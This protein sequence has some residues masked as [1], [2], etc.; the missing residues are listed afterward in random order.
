MCIVWFRPC[1]RP[2]YLKKVFN[3]SV[4]V[5]CQLVCCSW[6]A[7]AGIIFFVVVMVQQRICLTAHAL[8][9]QFARSIEA[10]ALCFF[11]MNG[12]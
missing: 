7:C 3:V 9:Q 8:R 1:R 2:P 12:M 11:G 6:N 10:D 4:E 5:S